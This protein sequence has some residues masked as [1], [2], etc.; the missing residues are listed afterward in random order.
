MK[1]LPHLLCLNSVL[2][3]RPV[4]CSG[5]NSLDSCQH[6]SAGKCVL[7]VFLV[8][9]DG[10]AAASRVTCQLVPVGHVTLNED[11]VV[12]SKLGVQLRLALLTHGLVQ[13]DHGDLQDE[14]LSC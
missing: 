3:Q 1:S 2:Y 13:V 11:A 7:N 6:V 4:L 10:K 9:S 8:S 14:T 12:F 5:R